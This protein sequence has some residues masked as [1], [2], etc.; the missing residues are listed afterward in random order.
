MK[1]IGLI[2]IIFLLTG[3]YNY[4][5]LNKIGIVS[6]ISIDLN[7]NEYLVGAQVINVKSKE[8]NNSSKVIVFEEK[9]KTI[10]E[11]LRKITTKSNKKLFGGHLNKLV[12]S[13]KV[14]KKGIINITDMFQR[15]PEIKDEFNIVIAKNIEANKVIK[16]MTSPEIIP[17]D[18]VKNEINL[19]Y[20]ES[21]LTYSSK[22][23]EFI[24]YYL[25]KYIDP[26]I[27]VIKINNYSNSGTKLE[28]NE[29]SFPKTTIET[30]NIA[31][32][33]DGKLEGY[34]NSEETIGYNFIR[35]NVKKMVIPIKCDN[36]NYTSVSINKSKTKNK[37]KKKN[38]E[39]SILLTINVDAAINEYN[40]SNKIDEK[41][42]KRIEKL[43]NNIIKQKIN[44]VIKMQKN[45]KS[46]FLGL[47][48][49]I[50]LEYPNYNNEKYKIN[51]KVNTSI[52]KKGE[53]INSSKGEK[54]EYKD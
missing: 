38:N 19:A 1:K 18:Y 16:I 35:N 32:T 9:G 47:K 46:E 2:L 43:T 24:S 37:I 14:A 12:L 26:V 5:E 15:L 50:Y 42:L 25:K 49:Y 53:L 10:E 17:A 54:N 27:T 31:Y 48:R 51:I 52:S 3:C 22:L 41:E 8:D 44:K 39:Y 20:N 23:D 30:D 29:T 45:V 11:A 33:Y 34:L 4:N 36:N 28:N 7:D 21:S 13:E 6:S 40:C